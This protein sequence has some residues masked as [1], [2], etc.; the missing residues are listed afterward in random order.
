VV[1]SGNMNVKGKGEPVPSHLWPVPPAESGRAMTV[2]ELGAADDELTAV[3]V[4]GRADFSHRA[5]ALWGAVDGREH[6]LGIR[7]PGG[8]SIGR[9]F[10]MATRPRPNG[11]GGVSRTGRGGHLVAGG[12]W[13]RRCSARVQFDNGTET[14]SQ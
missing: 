6:V 9:L 8:V 2:G 11:V 14:K 4:D 12:H 3:G 5:G 10:G 7:E 1:D 13:A